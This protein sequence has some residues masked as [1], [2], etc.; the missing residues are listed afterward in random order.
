MRKIIISMG[1]F[2]MMLSCAK[3]DDHKKFKN[4]IA[5]ESIDEALE[6]VLQNATEEE[7]NDLI[8]RERLTAEYLFPSEF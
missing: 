7:V 2:L 1:V 4:S 5:Q 8:E 3:L 6:K